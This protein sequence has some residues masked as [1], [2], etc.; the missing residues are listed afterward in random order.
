[1]KDAAALV[2]LQPVLQACMH[3]HMQ[4]SA[5]DGCFKIAPMPGG[6]AAF[7]RGS[8]PQ[9]G[10]HAE[11]AAAA[12]PTPCRA[13]CLAPPPLNGAGLLKGRGVKCMEHSHP[14]HP[15][16]PGLPADLD[17]GGGAVQPAGAAVLHSKQLGCI[18]VSTRDRRGS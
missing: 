7:R 13:P 10:F 14:G 8:I 5:E 1:M 12:R 6:T 15:N 18:S 2:E 16:G 11:A 3:G 17:H 4:C 9:Q